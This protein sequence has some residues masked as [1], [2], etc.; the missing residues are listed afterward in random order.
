MT[1]GRLGVDVLQRRGVGTATPARM[2]ASRDGEGRD[3]RLLELACRCLAGRAGVIRHQQADPQDPWTGLKRS[4]GDRGRRVSR[5]VRP[6][7]LALPRRVRGLRL[8]ETASPH[9]EPSSRAGPIVIVQL[10]LS[11]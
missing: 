11:T 1:V 5:Q 8:T 6:A 2:G 7:G 10:A 3:I 9:D 4:Q